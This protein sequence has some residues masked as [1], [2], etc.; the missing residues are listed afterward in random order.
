MYASI[1]VIVVAVPKPAQAAKKKK[2]IFPSHESWTL[3]PEAVAGGGR[4]NGRIEV[5][6]MMMADEAA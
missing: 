6:A 5:A 2:A 3:V 4:K 1:I